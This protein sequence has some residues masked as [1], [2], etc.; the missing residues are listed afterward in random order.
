L[1]NKLQFLELLKLSHLSYKATHKLRR[2]CF[3]YNNLNDFLSCQELQIELSKINY[4]KLECDYD[5]IIKNHINIVTFYSPYYPES[6]KNIPDFPLLFYVAGDLNLLKQNI[7][8]IIGSR[9]PNLNN[10]K[11]VE[12]L[13]EYLNQYQLVIISGMA[14]GI[15]SVAHHNAAK[16]IAVIGTGI[17]RCYPRENKVLMDNLMVKQLVISEFPLNTEPRKMNFPRRNR[18]IAAIA[19]LVIIIEAKLNSGSISTTKFAL[20]FGKEIFA[21]PG[22]PY[23]Y[24]VMGT[25]KLIKEGA[26]MLLDF[27]EIIEFLQK[28]AYHNKNYKVQD[29][30]EKDIKKNIDYIDK[31]NKYQDIVSYITVEGVD[32]DVLLS[33]LSI[34]ADYLSKILAK[35]EF[36]DFIYTDEYGTI[37]KRVG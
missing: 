29:F 35:L 30:N 13:C 17:N 5:Y 1:H 10:I 21:V 25:N 26:N 6:L 7:V 14:R 27:S 20:D 11:L 8:A 31:K 24:K 4:H 15:D 36:E 37:Y 3:K 12:N 34:K 2:L 22:H 18:I 33:K 9:T 16:T 28:K 32:F 19:E 23:D